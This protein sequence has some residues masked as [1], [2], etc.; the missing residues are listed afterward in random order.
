MAERDTD[1]FAWSPAEVV[2]FER[3]KLLPVK[4]GVQ[5]YRVVQKVISA[6]GWD[7]ANSDASARAVLETAK[8]ENAVQ[9]WLAAEMRHRAKGRYHTARETEVAEANMPDIINAAVGA[10]VEVA[11][12][13]KHGGK[14]WSTNTSKI[15]CAINLPKIICGRPPGGM[16]CLL[17][18]ITAGKDGRIP[19]PERC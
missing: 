15:P 12:E 19:R 2:A 13:A 11:V 3:D 18:P 8:D 4:T 7:F 17:S 16:G 14:N 1:L 10:Q 5:L 6:I 9:N